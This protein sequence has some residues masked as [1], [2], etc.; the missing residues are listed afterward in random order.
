MAPGVWTVATDGPYT[1][2]IDIWAYGYAIA[3]ILVCPLQKHPG[4]KFFYTN[5]PITRGRHSAILSMLRAHC[6]KAIENEPLVNLV[7]KLLVWK[8]EERWSAD[9]ALQHD[10]CNLITRLEVNRWGRTLVT[11]L[12]RTSVTRAIS[13]VP[14]LTSIIT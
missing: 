13:S 8:L 3:E 9:Q 2:K 7:S 11:S 12:N 10:C 1:A 4:P 14:A 5:A 6:S